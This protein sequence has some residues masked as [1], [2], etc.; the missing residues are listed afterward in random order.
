MLHIPNTE[1]RRH[2]DSSSASRTGRPPH[3]GQSHVELEGAANPH[4]SQPSYEILEK[5]YLNGWGQRVVGWCPGDWLLANARNHGWD[6]DYC[7]VCLSHLRTQYREPPPT[8]EDDFIEVTEPV[9][10]GPTAQRQVPHDD[11]T[12]DLERTATTLAVFVDPDSDRSEADIGF[13]K[14]IPL[15]TIPRHATDGLLSEVERQDRG[16]FDAIQSILA[17]NRPVHTSTAP[18][19]TR[20]RLSPEPSESGTSSND[21]SPVTSSSPVTRNDD[22]PTPSAAPPI[23]INVPK[24]P[25]SRGSSRSRSSH[26]RSVST[27]GLVLVRDKRSPSTAR[28]MSRPTTP[29]RESRSRLSPPHRP[30]TPSRLSHVS[31]TNSPE[32]GTV[33]KRTKTTV[34]DPKSHTAT[35]HRTESWGP[36]QF[37]TSHTTHRHAN[38]VDPQG[39]NALGSKGRNPTRLKQTTTST[40]KKRT[41]FFL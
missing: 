8:N 12:V 20:P 33:I 39:S 4:P 10:P 25:S 13:R 32:R 30:A 31:R 23:I 22:P 6:E 11:T 14:K 34:L 7:R 40:G 1:G 29:T 2:A 41:E 27:S 37:S 38:A 35:V 16:R 9:I 15:G 28:V 5:V 24:P 19:F 18:D 17:E 36:S 26:R 3:N 21:S